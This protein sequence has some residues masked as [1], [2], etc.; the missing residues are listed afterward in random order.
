MPRL[1]A[2]VF[3]LT[4]HTHTQRERIYIVCYEAP[5]TGFRLFLT[6]NYW[7]GRNVHSTCDTEYWHTS[8][9]WPYFSH[10]AMVFIAS[11]DQV[12]HRSELY[13]G[14]ILFLLWLSHFHEELVMYCIIVT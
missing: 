2:K 13:G 1:L 14:F 11:T 9:G 10:F 6:A 8:N 4:T 3:G 12:I 5:H 7:M